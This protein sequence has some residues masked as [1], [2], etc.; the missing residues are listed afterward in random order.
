MC[1]SWWEA[2]HPGSWIARRTT[3]FPAMRKSEWTRREGT[4]AK[5]WI[6]WSWVM[7]WPDSSVKTNTWW[8]WRFAAV[9][10][11]A[12]L[13]SRRSHLSLPTRWL[14]KSI[15]WWQR[16]RSG[17]MTTRSRSLGRVRTFLWTFR[18]WTDPET[19]I[20]SHLKREGSLNYFESM[21]NLFELT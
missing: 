20:Q 12:A 21:K 15:R 19:G 4:T 18:T 14:R 6:S 17:W 5:W 11:H 2:F 9:E 7:R 8:P 10:V 1:W 13:T 16:N 3:A